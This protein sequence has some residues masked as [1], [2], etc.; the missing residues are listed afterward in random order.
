MNNKST[1]L[2][3]CDLKMTNVGLG[4][5]PF[6][7]VFSK[8]SFSEIKKIIHIFLDFGGKYIETAPIYQVS[9]MLKM[10]IK[11]IHRDKYWLSSRCSL[12]PDGQGGKILSGKYKFIQK[13]CEDELLS[14]G[15]DYLDFYLVHKV[16]ED[17]ELSETI[18]ALD[19]LKARGRILHFGVS[20]VTL[21]DLKKLKNIQSI[22]Y[23]QN[24]YSLINRA[25][26]NEFLDYCQK[27]KI[28]VIPYQVIERGLLTNK[29]ISGFHVL[30]DGD[31]RKTKPEFTDRVMSSVS[32]WSSRYLKPIADDLGI[33]IE[34][35]AIRW[36]LQQPMVSICPVGVTNT[37]Q[38]M[39]NMKANHIILPPSTIDEIDKAFSLLPSEVAV[40]FAQ[41]SK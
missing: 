10:A 1:F 15:T 26:S 7:N 16:P 23:I 2:E 32:K 29:G 13:Q 39:E 35:L 41:M 17:V 30:L 3:N 24:R 36:A 20:N 18:T 37:S 5:F 25:I 31:L 21:S 38:L 4:T 12:A 8:I 33:S 6:S 19:D 22:E 40:C 9:N 34:V 14:L 27:N 11:D 28:G